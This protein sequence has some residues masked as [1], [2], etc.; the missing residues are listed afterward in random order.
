MGLNKRLS[1]IIGMARLLIFFLSR[2]T[3]IFFSRIINIPEM[4]PQ[5]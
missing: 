3:I 2:E 4:N 1:L 5:H